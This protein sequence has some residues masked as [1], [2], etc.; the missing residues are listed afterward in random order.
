[1]ANK[2]TAITVA[3]ILFQHSGCKRSAK[4]CLIAIVIG[5]FF[6]GVGFR[7][8]ASFIFYSGMNDKASK[9]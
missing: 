3:A 4:I 1:M 8:H 2:T 9:M 5:N 6:M 7:G